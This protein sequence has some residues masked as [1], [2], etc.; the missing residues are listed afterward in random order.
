MITN[1]KVEV[2]VSGAGPAGLFFA[3]QMASRGHSVCIVDPKPGPTD[4]SR[5]V[6]IT[7]RTLEILQNKGLA[8]DILY[9]AFAASGIRLYSK[10]KIVSDIYL[11]F[12]L[13]KKIT[14]S[15]QNDE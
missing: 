5:A 11:L 12:F 3:F 14:R 15:Y 2:L 9:D 10:G 1:T 7:A 4:Q 13:L 8:A 6:L